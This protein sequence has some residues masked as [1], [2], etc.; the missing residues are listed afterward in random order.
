GRV[1]GGGRGG[2]GWGGRGGG[3]NVGERLQKG[4]E[5]GE[6]LAGERTAAA[7]VGAFELGRARSFEAK[8]KPGGLTGVPVVRALEGTRP[9]GVSGL[10]R[11][12]VG[13]DNELELL[14]AT[15][16]PAAAN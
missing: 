16:R 11:V 15:Y 3:V 9:R 7:V 13:R 2:G 12:F 5:P 4:A 10:P 8:G 6:V 1:G 14:R